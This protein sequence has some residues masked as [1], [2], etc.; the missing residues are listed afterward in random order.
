MEKKIHASKDSK[1]IKRPPDTP[2]FV[3]IA[4]LPGAYNDSGKC[5]RFGVTG[6]GGVFDLIG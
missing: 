1:D 4:E 6:L 3:F 5:I 2:S